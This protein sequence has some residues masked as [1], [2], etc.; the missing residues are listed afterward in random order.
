MGLFMNSQ[1]FI[2]KPVFKR[3]DQKLPKYP[4]QIRPKLKKGVKKLS[5]PTALIGHN[6]T[7]EKLHAPKY[8]KTKI[9]LF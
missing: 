2:N 6:G 1:E 3:E 8:T 5:N 7:L 4:L 9:K